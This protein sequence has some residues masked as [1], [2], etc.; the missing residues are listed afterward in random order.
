MSVYF[1]LQVFVCIYLI[2]ELETVKK[3]K[4]QAFSEIAVQTLFEYICIGL[5]TCIQH[6]AFIFCYIFTFMEAMPLWEKNNEDLVS[7]LFAT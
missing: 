5:F 6:A 3:S 4:L 2:F 7:S 1:S